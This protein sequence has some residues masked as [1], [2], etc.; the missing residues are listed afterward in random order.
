MTY[1]SKKKKKSF[2]KTNSSYPTSQI[3]WNEVAGSLDI[4]NGHAARMRFSRFKQ[5]MEGI[6]PQVRKPKAA[7]VPRKKQK[8]KPAAAATKSEASP[9]GVEGPASVK[10]ELGGGAGEE[11]Q[12]VEATIKTSP[13]VKPEPRE[14]DFEHQ[15][16]DLIPNIS[17]EQHGAGLEDFK[18][19]V[20]E[21]DFAAFGEA[22]P[23][24]EVGNEVKEESFFKEEPVVKLE[25]HWDE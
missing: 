19:P 18:A 5:Q 9:E 8:Q 6:Q 24:F 12:G 10:P 14:E 13:I 23:S 25:P 20:G 15:Q 3:D 22:P 2:L 16:L 17:L 1:P 4:T 7:P 21:L 11:M